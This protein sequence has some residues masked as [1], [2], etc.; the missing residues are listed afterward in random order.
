MHTITVMRVTLQIKVPI[1]LAVVPTRDPTAEPTGDPTDVP[2]QPTLEPTAGPTNAP[3]QPTV[4]PTNDP[5]APTTEPTV[6][7]S[8]YPS[9][10][11]TKSPSYAPCNYVLIVYV[12]IINFNV[13]SSH[14][15]ED[16]PS[17][18]IV[19]WNITKFSI[20]ENTENIGIDKNAFYVVFMNVSYPLSMEYH[21]CSA[22]ESTVRGLLEFIQSHEDEIGA[23][24]ERRLGSEYGVQ[25]T[26]SAQVIIDVRPIQFSRFVFSVNEH[27]KLC[28]SYTKRRH[29][30]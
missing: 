2:S 28:K 6:P 17:Q 9:E 20:V 7:P 1:Q 8:D 30:S 26:E 21:L 10:S 13:F 25:A 12:E 19:M 4:D 18:Q 5:T 29:G 14:W 23:S 15:L 3:T 22:T 11:P 27:K 16:D 24:M